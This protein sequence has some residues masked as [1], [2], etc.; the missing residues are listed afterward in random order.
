MTP[1][2]LTLEQIFMESISRRDMYIDVQP[3]KSA[4]GKSS[5]KKKMSSSPM[6]DLKINEMSEWDSVSHAFPFLFVR[7]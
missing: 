2:L 1:C 7:F 6:I 5:Q 3:L 4:M